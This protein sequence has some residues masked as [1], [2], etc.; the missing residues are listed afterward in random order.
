MPTLTSTHKCTPR[1][2]V[3]P[4]Q[5]TAPVHEYRCLYT[6][7]LYKKA[8]KWHDGS[9]R[10][11]TF[12][13]RVM[14]YDDSKN[15]I[16]D[17]HY[18]E[19]E[20]F[21]EGVEIQLDRGVKVEVGELS[22]QTETDLSHILDRQRAEKPLQPSKQPPAQASQRPKSLLE[23]LGPSQRRLGRSRLPLQSPYE[24]R[25]SSNV[26]ESLG[27]PSKRPR[28]FSDVDNHPQHVLGVS[29]VSRSD[30]I[31]QSARPGMAVSTKPSSF[32]P[33]YPVTS[34]VSFEEVVDIPS[35]E[36][37][38]CHTVKPSISST[39]RE[40]NKGMPN[41]APLR[42]KD[43][44][45]KQHSKRSWQAVAA[46]PVISNQRKRLEKTQ[47]PPHSEASSVSLPSRSSEPRPA[48]LLL[49]QPQPRQKLIYLLPRP[50]SFELIQ[51]ASAVSPTSP[52][53]FHRTS[54][55][56]DHIGTRPPAVYLSAPSVRTPHQVDLASSGSPTSEISEC[57]QISVNDNAIPWSPLF[58]PEEQRTT[59]SPSPG[60]LKT[61]DPFSSPD[62][63]ETQDSAPCAAA[64]KIDSII[65]NTG[66]VSE[67][68]SGPIVAGFEMSQSQPEQEETALLIPQPEA[69]T[70][71]YAHSTR[72]ALRRVFSENNAF[73]DGSPSR[74]LDINI[75][76]RSPLEVLENLN[77]RRSPSKLN[78]P[79]KLHRCASD[80]VALKT[81][82]DG[83]VDERLETSPR[84]ET[85]PWTSEESFLL[86]DWWPSE[87]E[88]PDLWKAALEVSHPVTSFPNMSEFSTRITTARQFLLNDVR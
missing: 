10:F 58:V 84:S 15:Y 25:Q 37:V 86:F 16:G 28:L 30:E 40:P 57:S 52:E 49:S 22:G 77:S 38:A 20:A 33:R 61:P 82:M 83:L 42:E 62:F 5:N 18:R 70:F 71:P 29:T 79:S 50:P 34:S 69:V 85:G 45:P 27:Q 76:P 23:V 56:P 72:R 68:R 12:N 51:P 43:Q 59:P 64:T 66:S 14:V 11:H 65:H 36:E 54:H 9:L 46:K 67:E 1:L 87:L 41:T 8:K 13:R 35:D 4:T 78:S 32:I 73:R 31:P 47:R 26:F 53:S 6:R 75:V 88:K 44:K 17:L 48:R 24:E 81:N 3:A 7:D 39:V 74:D 19:G 21:G 63:G 55:E 2:V 80:T 60:L